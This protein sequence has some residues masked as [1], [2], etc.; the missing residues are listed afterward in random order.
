[1]RKHRKSKRNKEGRGVGR[2]GRV[3][4]RRKQGR[5]AYLL[6]KT[7]QFDPPEFLIHELEK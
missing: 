5:K 7:L 1:M 4:T 3:E 6:N 2:E